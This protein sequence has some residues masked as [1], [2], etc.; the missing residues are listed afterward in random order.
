[1][2]EHHFLMKSAPAPNWMRTNRLTALGIR[3]GKRITKLSSMLMHGPVTVE[4]D[5]GHQVAIGFGMAGK[6]IVDPDL[7]D[8]DDHSAVRQSEGSQHRLI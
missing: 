5:A 2:E 1:K 4:L 3:P 6:I 7:G 8:K